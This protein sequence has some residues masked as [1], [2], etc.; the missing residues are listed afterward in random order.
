MYLC[1]SKVG[2][3]EFDGNSFPLR[4][5]QVEAHLMIVPGCIG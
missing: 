1:A 5:V 4:K 2:C 3:D